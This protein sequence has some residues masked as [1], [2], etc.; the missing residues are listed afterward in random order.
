MAKGHRIV[1]GSDPLPCPG[2]EREA[3][4]YATLVDGE[5]DVS[6][7]AASLRKMLLS[8]ETVI[9]RVGRRNGPVRMLQ[10]YIKSR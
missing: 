1:A 8:A 5:L 10:R 9:G 2:E 4:R 7:V 3:G 6:A